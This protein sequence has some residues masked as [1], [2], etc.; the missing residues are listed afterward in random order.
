MSRQI[1]FDPRFSL[2]PYGKTGSF[3]GTYLFLLLPLPPSR[4]LFIRI[5]RRARRSRRRRRRRCRRRRCDR[6]RCRCLRRR[7]PS[8]IHRPSS[9]LL[10]LLPLLSFVPLAS[11]RHGRAEFE[12]GFDLAAPSWS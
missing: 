5:P 11:F 6:R 10:P 9:S 3:F 1:K 4:L 2:H 7:Y 12:P 8:L